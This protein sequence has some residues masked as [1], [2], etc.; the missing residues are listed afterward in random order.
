MLLIL[1]SM[2]NRLQVILDSREYFLVKQASSKSGKSISEW[3]RALIRQRLVRNSAHV[4]KQGVLEGLRCLNL[5]APDID[6][7]LKEIDKGRF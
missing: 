2:S 5:P 7:M 3:V 4:K 1:I 6:T